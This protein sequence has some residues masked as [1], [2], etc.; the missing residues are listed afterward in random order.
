MEI[1]FAPGFEKSWKRLFSCNP[2]YMIPRWI[3][4][5]RFEIKMAWQRVFR[6]WDDTAS[7]S[8]WSVNAEQTSKQMRQLA[9]NIVG[10]PG[11]FFDADKEKD[12]NQCHRWKETLH[13]IADGFDAILEDD[14]LVNAL[15]EERAVLAKKF[16]EG[17]E[18]YKKYY[19]NLW[20]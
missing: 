2:W 9:D 6:G 1:K 3:R 17:M 19:R 5:G 16:D 8:H 7:W 11:E 4:D 20:D 10:C 15:P 14:D 18:L 12:G 13:K